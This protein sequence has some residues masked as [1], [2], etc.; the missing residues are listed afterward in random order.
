MVKGIIFDMDG[1]IINSEPLFEKLEEEIFRAYEI[2][3]VKEEV[4]GFIGRKIEDFWTYFK[5]KYHL[6]PSV[7]AL[8]QDHIIRY[9]R[10]LKSTK[11][12]IISY[13]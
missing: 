7:E 2:P 10:V 6:K 3:Y 13:G 5:D 9:K 1:V 4:D 11:E 8:A 12:N